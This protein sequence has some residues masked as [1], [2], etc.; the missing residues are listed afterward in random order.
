MSRKNAM[1]D[2]EAGEAFV[3]VENQQNEAKARK[4]TNAL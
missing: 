3:A 2:Q 4:E 1:T